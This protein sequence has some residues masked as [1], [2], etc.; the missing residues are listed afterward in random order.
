[1]TKTSRIVAMAALMAVGLCLRGPSA[2]AAAEEPAVKPDPYKARLLGLPF[3]Y[4][5][6]ETKLAFGVG[7]M[8]NFRAGR[9]KE[10]ARTSSVWA[11]ASYNLARQFNILIKPEIYVKG[12][13]L[14]FN[15]GLQYQ[16]APQQFYGVGNATQSADGESFTPRTFEV[17]LGVKRRVSGGLFGGLDFDFERTTMEKVEPGGLLE[18]GAIAGSR[19]GMIAGFGANLNWD[20]RDS[21]LFPLQGAFLQ[22]SA[23]AY[24]ATAGSDFSYNRIEL[25]LRKYWPLGTNRV[26]ATQAY[27]VSMGG[28]VPFYKLALL[29]GESLLRGYYRGRFRDKGLL[30]FQ[31]EFRAL[32]T[33]R[34]GVAGFAGLAD[35]FPGFGDVG[36]GRLKFAA[37]SGIRYVINKRDGATVRLDLAWGQESF[38]LYI[39][40][41]EAF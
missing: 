40:A 14:I 33:K 15:G 2:T 25:D 11:F 18:S 10:E 4:Y 6:P 8:L 29:G 17:R 9:I 7:S 27:L 36:A 12:N 30:L 3:I 16:R 19:G 20:T 23:D 39:T 1:M 41:R 32:I 22:V 13:S 38:G 26:L 37:G 24:G 28:N 34:I 5:S 35:V 31:A 21:V